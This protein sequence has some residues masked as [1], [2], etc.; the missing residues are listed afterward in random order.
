[1]RV[2][3]FLAIFW[4]FSSS[5]LFAKPV[6]YI[7]ATGGTIAGSADSS[8]SGE[9][10]SGALTV[11][12]ILASVPQINDIATIKGEQ[13]ASIGSHHMTNEVWLKLANRVNELLSSD[14]DAV[15]IT[16]GTDSIEE[17]AYFLNL[18]VKSD[19]PVVILGAMRPATSM[20][21]DGPLNIYNAVSV[22]VSEKSSGKGVML[23]MNDE[24]HSAR[25]V[26]KA[27]TTNTAAFISPNSGKIGIVNY[28]V[29]EFYMQPLRRHT[30]D[31]EFDITNL[32]E[33]PKVDILYAHAQDNEALVE[34][35]VKSGAK[36]IVMAGMGNGSLFP[37][38]E[39][40]LA[41]ANESGVVIVRS[42]RVGS[43]TTS[44]G[45]GVKLYDEKYGFLPA[46]TLNPQKA[47]VLLMLGLTKTSDKEKIK[48][49]FKT[50]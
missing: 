22:A 13:V 8:A 41:K 12:T 18:T 15:V 27:N 31:S 43:G 49:F 40:A 46:D 39:N 24:I 21:A 5:L 17:S 26:T 4:L 7:L 34:V 16:H 37:S 48:E 25:D 9:Y 33:L 50:Y 2:L 38:V 23:V 30:K 42:S 11:D 29:V 3:K 20:S 35:S 1:M 10:K 32:K 45:T 14:A 36:G 6:V 47:R 19:K 44:V 28:G